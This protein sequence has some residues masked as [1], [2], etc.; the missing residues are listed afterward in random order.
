M[1][2]KFRKS[3]ALLAFLWFAVMLQDVSVVTPVA[4]AQEL[5][6]EGCDGGVAEPPADEEDEDCVSDEEYECVTVE[7]WVED[8]TSCGGGHSRRRTYRRRREIAP[9][10]DAQQ[11]VLN[12]NL[13]DV[14]D[15]LREGE[16]NTTL[17]NNEQHLDVFLDAMTGIIVHIGEFS[18]SAI[19]NDPTVARV[20]L[21]TTGLFTDP[22]STIVGFSNLYPEVADII[23]ST[24]DELF[25]GGAM[26]N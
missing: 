12:R 26:E 18:D 8:E 24:F 17:A 6:I 7:E 21:V 20:T 25:N 5:E 3:G 15:M 10:D 2:L 1:L 11:S 23:N 19:L 14:P 16:M 4:F 13:N 9:L 22:V